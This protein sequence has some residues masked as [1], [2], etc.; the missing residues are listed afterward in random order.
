[1]S[2]VPAP[3]S[4]Y[5]GLAAF[6]DSAV[7]A[8]FFFGRDR[9]SQVIA[10]NLMASRLTVLFGPTGVGKTS[11]LRAGVAYKLRQEA[12]V[13]VRVH[14]SWIGDPAEALADLTPQTGR[15]LYLMLDQFEE[16][17]LYH[18]GD[19]AFVQELA[20]VIR[21]PELRVNVLVGIRE[22]TLA[23]LD[24]FKAAIPNLLSNRLRLENLDRQAGEA[25]IRGPLQRFNDLVEKERHVQVEPQLVAAVLDEV[26]TG[27]VEL[28]A[29]GRGVVSG[30]GDADRI[31]APF[32]Q[33]VMSRLWEVEHEAGSRV[34][35]H[36]TLQ[37]LGGAAEIVHDHLD[38]AMA[39]LSPQQK[40]AAAA[41]YNF[42]VTPSGSKIAHGI[43][44]LAGYAEIGEDEASD[45]LRRLARERIVRADSENGA[46]TRY[47]I[48]HD[49]LADAVSAW[50]SR[51]RAER[52]LHE[53][54]RRRRRAFSLA[55]FAVL[56]LVLVAA[57]AVFA[58]VERSHSRAEAQRAH[59]RELAA[60]ASSLLDL[61]PQRS[62]E[63]AIRAGQ[64]EGGSH[65]E[66]VLRDALLAAHQ[67]S[68]MRAGG[69]VVIARFDPTGRHVVT[70]ARDGKIRVYRLGSSAP[71]Q[72][73]DQGGPVTGAAYSDDGRLLLTSGADGSA[74]LWRADGTPLHRLQAGG[75]VTSAFFVRHSRRVLTIARH[76]V[77]RLW[78]T[79]D[80][81]LLRTIRVHGKARVKGAAVSPSGTLLVTFGG[82]RFARVYSLLTGLLVTRLEHKGFVHCAAFSPNGSSFLTCGH[83]GVVRVWSTVTGRQI[84]VLRGPE[85]GSAVADAVFSP[86]GILVAAAVTDGTARVWEARTGFQIGVMFGHSNPTNRVAFNAS[87]KAIATG[88]PDNRART[89]LAS[90]KPVAIL[91]GHSGAINSVAFSPDGR[92]VLTSSADGTARLWA[93]GTEPD[94]R[95]VARQRSITSL[96]LSA[97]GTRVLV[98]DAHGVARVRQIGRRRVLETVRVRGSVTAVAFGPDGPIIATRPTLSLA[99]S[100]RTNKIARGRSDG[101]VTITG[102]GARPQ[103]LHLQ[104][105]GVTAVAFSPDDT[106]LAAGDRKGN[107]RLW[108]LGS[109]RVL[110]T[111][112]AHKA[113]ITSV[114]FS[115]DGELLLTASRDHE[116]RIW[117]AQTGMLR[118]VIRWHFGPL[119]GAAFSGDGRWVMTAGP[120]AASVGSLTTWRR[121]L[122]LRGHT[123]PLI[124]AL[125]GGRDG[126]TVVTASK[127]GTIRVYRCDI[128][129]GIDELLQLARRRLRAS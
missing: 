9:D 12:G 123:R 87:G 41:M 76:S 75:P 116:A 98:G 72:I 111:F 104:R 95:M 14:S 22:D 70:G 64:L 77:I 59:A 49:V 19:R 10:A 124:G 81:K 3:S 8:L 56:G 97:D 71:E 63:L 121:L 89:W 74:R 7:D 120:S 126:R 32:L 57:L 117:S 73:L 37:A 107:V 52:A 110:R 106:L 16:F 79:E 17:F 103:V 113:L 54:E 101:S 18:E 25:A 91:A 40:D 43:R 50:R 67:R 36:E 85:P 78:R 119:G 2:E 83:E 30:K 102:K 127:D 61:E 86:N 114:T 35:R 112:A 55:A 28:G 6:E 27:R 115:P 84:R 65:E 23:L 109:G 125:F 13:D 68:V 24:E 42:L 92:S 94:L 80:A 44:D 21:R 51:Y 29:V 128:C 105:A 82:D 46:S 45:V 26:A 1:M 11:V 60:A 90:G 66:D 33:L 129:G 39:E 118:H 20:D 58:L 47:E 31:E 48:Y 122:L 99:V 34:L 62:I 69:P 96:A 93:S 4:P 38:R 53:A 100:T 108:E 5:K 88:S 15:D